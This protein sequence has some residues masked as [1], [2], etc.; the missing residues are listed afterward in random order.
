MQ[1]SEKYIHSKARQKFVLYPD[2][3][4]RWSLFIHFTNIDLR[5]YC[6]IYCLLRRATAQ[7]QLFACHVSSE[8]SKKEAVEW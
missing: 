1:I 4:I 8:T 3:K 5:W 6:E 7:N 2:R